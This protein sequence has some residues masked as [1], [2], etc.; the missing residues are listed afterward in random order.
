MVRL[1]GGCRSVSRIPSRRRYPR[2]RR[3]QLQAPPR[4]QPRRPASS[5]KTPRLPSVC[6]RRTQRQHLRPRQPPRP[7]QLPP[8]HRRP[9]ARP[10]RYRLGHR[11]LEQ[12]RSRAPDNRSEDRMSPRERRRVRRPSQAAGL[13]V[14]R[15]GKAA[16]LDSGEPHRRSLSPSL[17]RRPRPK[18]SRRSLR[19]P[20]PSRAPLPSS[21]PS[22]AS[23]R[24]AS[25]AAARSLPN[26][27]A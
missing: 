20:Q 4:P 8:P 21:I 15:A 13:L 11:F 9:P 26:R 24:R 6:N 12:P 23:A 14:P 19:A 5:K 16:S 18:A 3:P 1:A 7:P 25:R 2:L 10:L 22:A 27:A 17:P